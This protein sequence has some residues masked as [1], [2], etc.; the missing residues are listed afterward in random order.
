MVV[1]AELVYDTARVDICHGEHQSWQIGGS[2]I[3]ISQDNIIADY[4]FHDALWGGGGWVCLHMHEWEYSASHRS[5]PILRYIWHIVSYGYDIATVW[6]S[7]WGLETDQPTQ[8][9]EGVDIIQPPWTSPAQADLAPGPWHDLRSNGYY[10]TCISI[11]TSPKR[12][13]GVAAEVVGAPWG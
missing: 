2:C 4:H 8:V 12:C 3:H 10:S 13:P 6:P 7:N 9:G 1:G 11:S 5:P